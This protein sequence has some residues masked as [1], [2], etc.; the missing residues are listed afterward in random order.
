MEPLSALLGVTVTD[1]IS[2]ALPQTEDAALQAI[3]YSV[4]E[5][6]EKKAAWRKKY[7]LL[8]AAACLL[9]LFLLFQGYLPAVFQRG[10]PLPYLRAAA[11]LSEA[12]P[13]VQVAARGTRTV[14]LTGRTV[15]AREALFSEAAYSKGFSLAEQNG[16]AYIFT[17]GKNTLILEEEIYLGRYCV[18]TAPNVTYES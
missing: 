6:T 13:Y 5:L 10:D 1:L 9:A 12:H 7:V 4:R 16:S 18:W 14:Y 3:Q 17:D 15:A 2:G 11:R 8:S